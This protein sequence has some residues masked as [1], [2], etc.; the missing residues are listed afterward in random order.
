MRDAKV[1]LEDIAEALAGIE[2]TLADVDLESFGQ[3]WQMQRA[4][5]RGLEIISEASR[6]I[7][8]EQKALHPAVPWAQIAG[9][10]NILRHEY[11]RVEPTIIWNITRTHLRSLGL[12]VGAMLADAG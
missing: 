9:I 12:A 4:I 5:E 10:G 8:D 7:P 3:S 2:H 11:H 1:R 6:G